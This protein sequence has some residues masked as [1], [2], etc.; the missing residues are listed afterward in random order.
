MNGFPKASAVIFDKD[1]TLMDTEGIH[2]GCWEEVSRERGYGHL[3]FMAVIKKT[4]GCVK[5]DCVRILLETFGNDFPADDLLAASSALYKQRT[6]DHVPLKAG[7]EDTVRWLYRRRI[8]YA[9]ASSSSQ[10]TIASNLRV[11][12]LHPYFEHFVGGNQV[13]NGK[14]DPEIFLMT[15]DLLKVR[16]QECLVFE[17]SLNGAVAA[18]RAK[19]RVV[20]VPDLVEITPE[21]RKEAHHVLDSLKEAIPLLQGFFGE[22]AERAA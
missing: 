12:G 17:D 10:E 19:M 7:A 13:K 6:R 16:P 8:P 1:G 15:A 9:I 3:D 18:L 5:K 4:I 14:P 21:V 22:S 20:I 11:S 2:V